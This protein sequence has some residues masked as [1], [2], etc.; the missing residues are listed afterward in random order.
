MMNT[1]DITAIILTMIGM[2]SGWVSFYL[3]RHKH[4]QE[5]EGM[6]ADNDR[7]Y[8]DLAT[9]FAKKFK[10]LIAEPLEAQ[11]TELRTEV[12]Q[13]RNAINKIGDCPHSGHCPVHDELRKQQEDE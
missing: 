11:I 9:E 6:K 8:L 12:K 7:K 4:K 5:I 1:I 10:E 2:V 3:D 13:L